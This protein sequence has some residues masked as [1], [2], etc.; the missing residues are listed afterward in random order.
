MQRDAFAGREGVAVDP[1]DIAIVSGLYEL[2]PDN[3][4]VSRSLSMLAKIVRPGG[5]LIYSNQPWHPQ[6][7]TIAR[8]LVNRNGER[9][10][11]RRRRQTE[12]DALV[13]AANFDKLATESDQFGIFNVS[14]AQRR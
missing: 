4:L 2:I 11:M 10:I 13:S 14:L 1:V 7:E 3:D 5:L 8:T 9:W 12:M 6:L